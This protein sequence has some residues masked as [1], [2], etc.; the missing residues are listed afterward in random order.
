MSR[1]GQKPVE[2]P[3]GVTVDVKGLSVIVKGAKGELSLSTSERIRAEVKDGR[4][5]FTRTDD[6]KISL[7][8]HG[9]M[10]SLV[11]NMIEGVSK[12]F[13]KALEIQGVGYRAAVQGGKLVMTLGFSSPIEYD[14]PDGVNVKVD[15]GTFITIE[16]PDKQKVGDVAARIRLFCPVEP[17][18][19]KGV[20]YRG[21]QVKRKVGKT[22]A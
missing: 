2:I 6:S 14:V 10:R 17:Y 11:A 21:E 1:I 22:V 16:G 8:E 19:G 7:S 5:I 3:S 4:V 13:S 18:K 12:G 15:G 20:R 9:L